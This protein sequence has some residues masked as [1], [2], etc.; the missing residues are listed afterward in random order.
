MILQLN[1]IN[2]NFSLQILSIVSKIINIYL[3]S[4]FLISK[5]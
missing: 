2:W 1:L 4:N 3:L 5:S